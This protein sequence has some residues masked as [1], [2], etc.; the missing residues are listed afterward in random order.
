MLKW[1]ILKRAE[2]FQSTLQTRYSIYFTTY[3][4]LPLGKEKPWMNYRAANIC[5]QTLQFFIKVNI[6]S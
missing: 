4:R 3:H 5:F 6:S 1:R 2:D